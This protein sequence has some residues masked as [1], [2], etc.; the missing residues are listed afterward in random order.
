MLFNSFSYA[1]FLPIV[2]IIYWLLPQRLKWVLLLVASY[3]FY[4]NWNAKYIFLIVGITT[5]SY[6]MAILI[7]K[8]DQKKWKKFFLIFTV[9]VCLG[10]LFVFKYYN[11]FMESADN[12]LRRFSLELHP[13]TLKLLLPVGISFYTFQTISYVTDVYRGDIQAE[14]HF[15]YYATF[16]AFFPQLVAGPIERTRN[17]LPQIKREH[18]FDYQKSADGLKLMLW[19][20]YKKMVVA[21]TLAIYVD[22]VYAHL[23]NYQ[24]FPLI[25]V[26]F[27]FTLQIYCDFSGYSNIAVGTAKLLDIDLM[28]NFNV[29]YF[30]KSVKEFW[31]RW[32]I[33]LSTWFKDYVYIPLGGNRCSKIRHYFNLMVTFLISGLW[34]GADWTYVIWGGIHGGAQI[35]ED[36]FRMPLEKLK[37]SKAGGFITWFVVF[38]FCNVAWVLF[39][40]DTL[41]GAVYVYRNMFVGIKDPVTYLQNGFN[42]IGISKVTLIYLITLMAVLIIVD[43]WSLKED[44]IQKIRTKN[45]IFGWCIYGLI[46]LLVIFFSRKGVA[47]EFVYFQF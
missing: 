47:A 37:K 22:K 30:S 26:M 21:D 44:I 3:Y 43:F 10:T 1:I 16:I 46:A 8:T 27:F 23:E 7:E 15:G 14:K 5:V 19:G 29:P 31:K 32:H 28:T 34:H 38:V 18:Y 24:G 2:F 39:R 45:K 20:Y 13:V 9:I 33:S 6:I 35:I 36:L 25:I 42:D 41:S 40:A 17:L 11:F 4:M 12:L